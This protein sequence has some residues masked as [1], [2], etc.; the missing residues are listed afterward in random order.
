MATVPFQ[1]PW[2]AP[3]ASPIASPETVYL[4]PPE[5]GGLPYLAPLGVP[6]ASH[7]MSG[8]GFAYFAPPLASGLPF[9]APARIEVRLVMPQVFGSG[10]RA[11]RSSVTRAKSSPA[12]APVPYHS[13]SYEQDERAAL[14]LDDEET[15]I[16]FLMEFALH[17]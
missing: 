15:V 10:R 11:R 8:G 7:V 5:M 14:E 1:A 6:L 2:G 16:A 12:P 4:A 3:L 9:L 17:V 13:R